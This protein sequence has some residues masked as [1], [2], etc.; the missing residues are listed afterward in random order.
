M[1]DQTKA[2]FKKIRL[3]TYSTRIRELC[4]TRVNVC[5]II[6]PSALVDRFARKFSSLLIRQISIL[7]LSASVHLPYVYSK[8]CLVVLVIPV[9]HIAQSVFLANNSISRHVWNCSCCVLIELEGD[10]IAN[11]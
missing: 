1:A 10:K 8:I 5:Q 4:L 7:H 3:C 11:A 2:E 6:C 9:R